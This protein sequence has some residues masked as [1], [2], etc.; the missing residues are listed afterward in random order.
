MTILIVGVNLC[1]HR[2]PVRPAAT[3]TGEFLITTFDDKD[4]ERGKEK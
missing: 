4:E 3:L 2:K 1:A